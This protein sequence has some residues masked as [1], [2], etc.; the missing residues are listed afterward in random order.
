MV[1]EYYKLSVCAKVQ[2]TGIYP[3]LASQQSIILRAWNQIRHLDTI[4]PLVLYIFL[5]GLLII[6]F[7]CIRKHCNILIQ[8]NSTKHHRLLHNMYIDTVYYEL[9]KVFLC[10]I[11]LLT[12]IT[13]SE[14][15]AL[16][17]HSWCPKSERKPAPHAMPW[18]MCFD[19]KLDRESKKCGIISIHTSCCL[20]PPFLFSLDSGRMCSSLNTLD[21][22]GLLGVVRKRRHLHLCIAK[23]GPPCRWML[24]AP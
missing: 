15:I 10:F 23:Q 2:L 6:T 18:T 1:V 16:W 22:M 17:V 4:M 24:F 20:Q 3:T 12:C 11:I 9:T 5:C 19:S 14:V 13:L 21:L 7:V 8:Y